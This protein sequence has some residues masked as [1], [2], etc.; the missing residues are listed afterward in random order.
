MAV[1]VVRSTRVCGVR[2]ASATDPRVGAGGLVIVNKYFRV[3][4][5]LSL[6]ASNGASEGYQ[7][8]PISLVA[9]EARDISTRD[10]SPISLS[11]D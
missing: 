4:R 11:P 10:I 9:P 7:D 2:L 3:G 1:F 5:E 8:L 6:L